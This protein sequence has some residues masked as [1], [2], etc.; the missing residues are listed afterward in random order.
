MSHHLSPTPC[1]V[2]FETTKL[3][4]ETLLQEFDL[5]LMQ[6]IDHSL[7]LLTDA[8]ATGDDVDLM[9]AAAVVWCRSSRARE[10]LP[11]SA[12]ALRCARRLN[13]PG[14]LIKAVTCRGALAGTVLNTG[15]AIESHLEVVQLAQAINEPRGLVT[16]YINL[17][18]CC[19]DISLDRY[20]LS[21]SERALAVA[22]KWRSRE[23]VDYAASAEIRSW[24]R[25]AD[26]LLRTG[27]NQA[28]LSAAKKCE[29][30]GLHAMSRFAPFERPQNEDNVAFAKCTALVAL[31][32][33][34]LLEEARMQ[35]QVLDRGTV[36]SR[37]E[38]HARMA[39]AELHSASGEFDDAIK[40]L[41]SVIS[42]PSWESYRREAM[43]ALVR[44][45]ESIGSPER[46]LDLLQK[47]HR[48]IDAARR[49][50]AL[51]EVRR[52]DGTLLPEDDDFDRVAHSRMATYRVA[53]DGIGRRLSSKLDYLTELAASTEI[54]EG[55]EPD[56]AEH[57]Y[58]VGTLCSLLAAEAG[59]SEEVCWM[60]DVSGR[61]HDLGKSSIP[62]TLVL[63]RQPLT[64]G[65]R[66]ILNE[67]SE[68]G[69][70]LVMDANEPRLI[71]VV[72]AIRHHHE[73][74][75]GTGYPS[76]LKG[77]L[78]P[79]LARIV[80]LAE[81][82][83]AMLQSRTYRPSR[84]VRLALEEI[85]RCAGSQFDPRLAGVFV[86]LIRRIEH[87]T[88]DLKEHLGYQGRFSSA[89]QTFTA[90]EKSFRAPVMDMPV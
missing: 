54:R 58:R 45:Y 29:E 65:E 40:G 17:A 56:R 6:N 24:E 85:E 21:Y 18:A 8:A 79:I 33:V 25:L 90:L 26:A 11:I 57:V 55:N 41:E 4:L 80:A 9:I 23:D 81:S 39:L 34:G 19:M 63:K 49:E 47:L 74:F 76:G 20:A 86:A 3:Q 64:P 87:K 59:L 7:R 62:D 83:D 31:A 43:A 66:Q 78:I 30:V 68:V 60:A 61:L 37:R 67:H 44:C 36:E 71:Q 12:K 73:R 35:A 15:T 84:S 50:V 51:E 72:A 16:G 70:R 53:V 88:N 69:A 32:R 89:V 13:D 14:L 52:F 22:Q 2:H 77:E 75:D 27:D 82:F 5:P 48:E 38:A 28:A 10:A 46:A 1:S 42:N